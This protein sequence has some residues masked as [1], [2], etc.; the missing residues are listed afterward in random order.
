MGIEAGMD[1]ESLG[2]TTRI[3]PAVGSR[4]CLLLAHWAV[5]A[6]CTRDNPSRQFRD[7]HRLPGEANTFSLWHP[8]PTG[9]G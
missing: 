9:P 4:L 6:P 8:L 3:V 5:L 7:V 2:P 1:L